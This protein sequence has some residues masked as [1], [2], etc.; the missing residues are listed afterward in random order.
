MGSITVL[1]KTRSAECVL[2][3][4]CFFCSLFSLLLHLFFIVPCYVYQYN[5]C[6]CVKFFCALV[7]MIILHTTRLFG[8]R[9]LKGPRAESCGSSDRH[10]VTLPSR[11]ATW[12]FTLQSPV[13]MCV[14]VCVC[15]Y[16]SRLTASLRVI[17]RNMY[18]CWWLKRGVGTQCQ[19]QNSLILYFSF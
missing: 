13:G 3:R 7:E 12:G 14:C 17:C 10:L 16:D 4:A 5:C 6:Y 9:R 1:R 15:I 11:L 8:F 18:H 19:Q 2:V